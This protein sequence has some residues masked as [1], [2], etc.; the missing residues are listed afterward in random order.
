[1]IREDI[2]VDEFIDVVEG[3]RQ[4][5]RCLYVINKIDAITM[6]EVDRVARQPHT[7]VISCNLELNLDRLIDVIWN[8][9]ELCRAYTKRRGLQ[10]DF[11]DPLVLRK[12]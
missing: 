9:L 10:P 4:Y 12:G 5:I 7:V 8:N 6:E 1:M 2:T 11:D 3:N